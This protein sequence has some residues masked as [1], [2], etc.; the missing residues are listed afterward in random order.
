MSGP[1]RRLATLST[2]GILLLLAA[3]VAIW[4]SRGGA[5]D[6]AR[7]QTARE[8]AVAEAHVLQA[9]PTADHGVRE[10]VDTPSQEALEAGPAAGSDA[11]SHVVVVVMQSDRLPIPGALVEITGHGPLGSW[12]AGD[13]GHCILPLEQGAE[14][15]TLRVSAEGFV[16]W[17]MTYGHPD[18]IE[19]ALHRSVEVRG[20]VLSSQDRSPVGSVRIS[21]LPYFYGCEDEVQQVESDQAGRFE[22]RGLPLEQALSWC[23][24]AEG[25]AT[26]ERKLALRDPSVEVEFA[27]VRG[28]PMELLVVDAQT[29]EPIEGARILRGNDE[30]ATDL[31]GRAET[32]ALLAVGEEDA[33]VQV[34]APTYCSLS[35]LIRASDLVPGVP[36]RLPLL[37][38]VRLEGR[39]HDTQGTPVGGVRLLLDV[40]MGARMRSPDKPAGASALVDLPV[41]W[42]LQGVGRVRGVS[43]EAGWFAFDGLEPQGRWYRLALLSDSGFLSEWQAVPLLGLP[44]SAIRMD[45]LL[46]AADTAVIT[47]LMTLN[48]EPA[49]GRIDWRGPSRAGSGPVARDGRFRLE[50]VEPGHVRLEPLLEG[51]LQWGGCEDRIPGSWAAEVAPDTEAQIDIALE[52]EMASIAGRV[53]DASG[54][55]QE[56]QQVEAF[57]SEACWVEL[58]WS[59]ADGRFELPVPAGPWVYSVAVGREPDRVELEGVRAGTSDLELMLPGT[60]KLRL[61][62]IDRRTR[63]SL[64]GITLYLEDEQGRTMALFDR[65]GGRFAPDPA[66]WYEQDLHPGLWWLLV[67]DLPREVSG[68]LPL[69]GGT[70]R[71]QAGDTPQIVELERERGLELE[72]R[73]ADGQVAW[74][75]EV[76][77]LLLE[78]DRAGEVEHRSSGWSMGRG[79][80]GLNI[81]DAR[82][83]QPD[84]NGH[85][86]AVALWGGPCRF[87]A[88]PDTIAIEPAEVVVTGQETGPVEI[89]WKPR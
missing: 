69:D 61:R 51:W 68:Y 57:S 66:G 81:L 86:R 74:P 39:V 48:G 44:G 36:M 54:V 79:Y 19:I 75:Q 9:P 26:L 1:S 12:Q 56:G 80:R 53:V 13:D 88:F 89:R 29:G 11:S 17:C 85:A 7:P 14:Q 40:D 23:V 46:R 49:G 28:L 18:R 43:D 6:A 27:L 33:V 37:E 25:F 84:A 78:A 4:W 31:R 83:I 10:L 76:S 16:P 72:V 82:R 21:I 2:A 45:M 60:G 73:L 71:I 41:G 87:V 58:S 70:V 24:R 65:R 63:A 38:G 15:V 62:A 59:S 5:S 55:P 32:T 77:V 8:A 20:L 35:A 64:T 67:G 22:L 3:L 34:Q 52:L 47:G 42:A 50:G 30:V